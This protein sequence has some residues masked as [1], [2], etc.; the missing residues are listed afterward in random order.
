[1]K[2]KNEKHKN[3]V[4]ADRLWKVLEIALED[5]KNLQEMGVGVNM[6][7]FVTVNYDNQENPFVCAVCLAGAVIYGRF[8]STNSCILP[9]QS[10]GKL[11]QLDMIRQGRIRTACSDFY[12]NRKNSKRA[13]DRLIKFAADETVPDDD[14]LQLRFSEEIALPFLKK[15]NL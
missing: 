5:M 8:G 15:H 2:Y 12:Q 4:K 10:K 7:K 14:I 6:S 3:F 13:F 9:Y 11:H 1:M